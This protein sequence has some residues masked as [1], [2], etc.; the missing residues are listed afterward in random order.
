MKLLVA[1]M[2]QEDKVGIEWGSPT[3]GK[4]EYPEMKTGQYGP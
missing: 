4:N 2:K 1:W 3:V